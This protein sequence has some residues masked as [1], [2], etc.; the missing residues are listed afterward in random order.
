MGKPKTFEI[1]LF[2]ANTKSAHA[3][4]LRG[5]F[6]SRSAAKDYIRDNE[7]EIN[8]YRQ[9]GYTWFSVNREESC[10]T[11]CEIS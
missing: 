10:Q 6:A 11:I 8:K 4:V 9:Q 5:G 3:K 2:K 7:E 1:K